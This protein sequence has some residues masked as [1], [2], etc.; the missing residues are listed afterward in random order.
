LDFMGMS[1]W[2]IPNGVEINAINQIDVNDNLELKNGRF[3][4]FL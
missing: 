2:S 3:L 1:L 4:F